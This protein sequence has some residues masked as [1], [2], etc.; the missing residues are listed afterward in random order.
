[1]PRHLNVTANTTFDHLPARATGNGWDAETVA[2]VDVES[3]GDE[4]TVRV[5]LELDADVD[6][7]PHH[8]AFLSL[9]PAQARTFAGDLERV[10]TAAENGE[11]ITSGRH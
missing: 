9:S 10:A 7:L 3:P 5:G 1:M 4:P 6:G 11:T 8:A 2:I